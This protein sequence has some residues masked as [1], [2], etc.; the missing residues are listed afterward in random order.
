MDGSAGPFVFLIQS[1]GIEE[2]NAA[3]KFIR[4]KRKVTVEDGDKVASFLP[5]DGFKVSFT[6]DFDQPVFRGRSAHVELD[7]SSATFVDDISQ[8]RTFGFMQEIEY[9]RSKGLARGGSVDN[10]IVVDEYRILNQDGLRYDD[11]FVRHKVLDAIG[12]LSL[13]GAPLMGHYHAFKSGHLMNKLL[14]YKLLTDRSAWSLVGMNELQQL[15]DM[16]QQLG[17]CSQCM[18]D[19]QMQDAAD[20]LQQMQG[21]LSDLQQQLDEVICQMEDLQSKLE[22]QARNDDDSKNDAMEE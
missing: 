4:I 20:M 5:F 3:K 22:Q 11:E 13:I 10:A 21:D 8:A 6:I 17:Q 7:F 1:A 15:Q 19:G 16:A 18:Q 2:Q 9:L 12:D 14:I